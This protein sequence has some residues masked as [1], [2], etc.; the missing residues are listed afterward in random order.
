METIILIIELIGTFA[1]AVSGAV[2]AV[3]SKLDIFGTIVLGATTAVGGGA[4]RDI[5]L[6][7]N[8]PV[9]FLKPVYVI[10]AVA[11]SLAVFMLEYF[12]VRAF[13]IHKSPSVKIINYFDALGLSVF[14]IVGCNVAISMGY[15]ANGFLVIFVGTLTGIGGGILRDLFVCKIPS[16]LKEKIYAIAAIA[17]GILYYVLLRVNAGEAVA[18]V[19]GMAAVILLRL[20]ATKYGWDLPRIREGKKTNESHI[21]SYNN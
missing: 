7:I 8:P 5:L 2:T 15:Y 19:C 13:K 11:A 10:V 3:E 16:V 17:G 6:G 12:N 20:F 21:S 4:I 18:M 14:L 9:L 1:F